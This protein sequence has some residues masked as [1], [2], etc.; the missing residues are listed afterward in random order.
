MMHH[1]N[2][3]MDEEKSFEVI[4]EGVAQ[5]V[6]THVNN[7]HLVRRGL[8]EV[9]AMFDRNGKGYLDETERALRR[10]DSQDR[11]YLGI[12]KVCVIFESLQ[13]EQERSSHLLEALREEN[14][15]SLSLKRAV[16]ALTFFTLL[17]ALANVGTSFAISNLVKDTQVEHGDL[18]VKGTNVRVGTTSRLAVFEMNS[19]DHERR[20]HL[21]ANAGLICETM[22]E[23]LLFPNGTA[24]HTEKEC[25]LQGLIKL[26]VAEDIHEQL[27]NVDRVLLTC[28]GK[29]S[30]LWGGS[31]LP[32]GSPADVP[33]GTMN[34]TV[35]PDGSNPNEKY[36]AVQRVYVPAQPFRP[37]VPGQAAQPELGIAAVPA[38]RAVAPKPSFNCN[39]QYELAMYCPSELLNGQHQECLVMSAYQPTP[40]CPTAPIVCGPYSVAPLIS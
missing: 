27:E 8:T 36:T 40:A 33:M 12:D 21:Q 7:P 19:I 4:Q 9:S 32:E 30:T 11:G 39:A 10:M 24:S 14:K 15:K 5:S 16:I 37:A 2:E 17:L 38:Q 18:M 25:S 26:D 6:T 1:K 31:D 28:N 20:R 35:F 13:A 22:A 23:T 34:M 3:N 29:K